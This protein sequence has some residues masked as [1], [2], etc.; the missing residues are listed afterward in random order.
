MRKKRRGAMRGGKVKKGTNRQPCITV[1]RQKELT[2][3][4]VQMK[5]KK[6][7]WTTKRE[8]GETRHHS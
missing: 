4:K 8:S 5:T 3:R 1:K 2:L 6:C 7:L